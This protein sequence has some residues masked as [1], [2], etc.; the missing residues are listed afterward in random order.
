MILKKNRFLDIKN[1][2]SSYQEFHF[3][4]SRIPFLHIKKTVPQNTFLDIEKSI[5]WYKK[6]ISWYQEFDFLISRNVFYLLISRNRILDIKKCWINSKTAP[7]KI[8]PGITWHARW[9]KRRIELNKD[10]IITTCLSWSVLMNLRLL[11]PLHV[12]H[13]HGHG[14]KRFSCFNSVGLRVSCR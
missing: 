2:I 11:G 12:L 13:Q 6:M 9:V 5:S 1:S 10:N 3:F 8:A 4:I 14:W 7:H